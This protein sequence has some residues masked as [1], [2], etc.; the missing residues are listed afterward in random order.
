M[1]NFILLLL[2]IVCISAKAQERISN[3]VF[4]G[5]KKLVLQASDSNIYVSSKLTSGDVIRSTCSGGSCSIIIEYKGRSVEVS[6]GDAI[7]NLTV[8]EYDFSLDGDMELVVINDFT[9]T[10]FLFVFSYSR[11]LIEKIFQYEA[12]YE[13]E[14]DANYIVYYLPSGPEG[15]WHYFKGSFWEMSPMKIDW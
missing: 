5:N 4:E 9:D 15:F 10:S 7:S 12:Y 8:Y 2:L 6:I 14:I 3:V 11:G 13:T 1:K